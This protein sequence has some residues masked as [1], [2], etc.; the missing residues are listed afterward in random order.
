M[1][2]V[3]GAAAVA[4]GGEAEAAG[5]IDAVEKA[6]EC[7][8]AVSEREGN[9]ARFGPVEVELVGDLAETRV[10]DRRVG[11]T[12]R[13]ENNTCDIV[14]GVSA[15]NEIREPCGH[16]LERGFVG[17]GIVEDVESDPDDGGV[18]VVT[19]DE[20]TGEFAAAVHDVVRPAQAEVGG[21]EIAQRADDGPAGGERKDGPARA[22]SWARHYSG[23]PETALVGNPAATGASA[24]VGL[25]IGA[26][27]VPRGE[28]GGS[29]VGGADF[30]GDVERP[31]L[32]VK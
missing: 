30:A 6:G 32:M 12:D 25:E 17:G 26:N 18:G 16:S 1:G 11:A 23:E 10:A 13:A 19:F 4:F 22:L 3:V 14:E 21:A 7:V 29:G 31:T 8:R 20:Q 2:G 9:E 28:F 24:P 27:G 5:G 15:G